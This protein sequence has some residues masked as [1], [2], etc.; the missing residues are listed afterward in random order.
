MLYNYPGR[1][2]VNMG[3]EYLRLVSA[4]KNFCA[5]KESSGDINRLHLLANDYPNIQLSC[6]ADDQALEFFV[7]GARSWVCAGVT[8]HPRLISRCTKPAS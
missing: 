1:T 5:I 3:E 2:V 6:G 7:W 8:S 4:S